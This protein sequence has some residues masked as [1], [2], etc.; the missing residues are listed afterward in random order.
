MPVKVNLNSPEGDWKETKDVLLSLS[1]KDRRK[2]YRTSNFVPLDDIP[3][4]TPT[5]GGSEPSRYQRNEK[6]DQ[7]ISLY[8][9]DITKL[10]IDA[11]V[12]A[13]RAPYMSFTLQWRGV[14]F[15]LRGFTDSQLALS[16]GLSDVLGASISLADVPAVATLLQCIWQ[17][18]QEPEE[19]TR[20]PQQRLLVPPRSH[21]LHTVR[22]LSLPLL[23]SPFISP[24][25]LVSS[26]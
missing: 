23:Q 20:S 8:S 22:S 7:K 3:V 5:A 26:S 13:G 21:R 14:I 24:T 1:V 9:G 12:N 2:H 16:T 6:F 4:W 11:I 25:A 19:V 18:Y 17:I 15:L 10:E